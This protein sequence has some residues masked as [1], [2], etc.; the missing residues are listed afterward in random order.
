M[1]HILH[2]S[3]I[4]STQRV[5]LSLVKEGA[6]D[7]IA[8]LSSMQTRGKGRGI[9]AWHSPPG[10]LY[11]SVVVAPDPMGLHLL[12]LTIGLELARQLSDGTG[13]GLMVKWPNDLVTIDAEGRMRKVAGVL[14]DVLSVSHGAPTAV[15]GLGVNVHPVPLPPEIQWQAAFLDEVTGHR[16]ELPELSHL[17]LEAVERAVLRIS[18][19][20]QRALIGAEL[21]QRL[22]G[23]GKEVSVD[24]VKGILLG[25]GESGEVVLSTPGGPESFF[26]GE[27]ALLER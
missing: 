5:A 4:D 3:E 11:L 13:S 2:Y 8:V 17:M 10:G 20:E 15:V 1:K 26:S 25:I 19:P 12:S 14:T 18:E 9:H 23:V 16:H 7:G 22:W 21:N 24:G 6:T 27:L